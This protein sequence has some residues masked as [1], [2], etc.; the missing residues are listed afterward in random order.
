MADE[1]QTRLSDAERDTWTQVFVAALNGSAM[2]AEK[3]E[4]LVT[5]AGEVADIAVAELVRRR[6]PKP[7]V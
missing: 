1:R 4:A 7:S 2:N 5:R 3:A 6:P